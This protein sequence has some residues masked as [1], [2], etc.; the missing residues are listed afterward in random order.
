M[1]KNYYEQQLRRGQYHVSFHDGKS[2]H[3]DGSPFYDGKILH[4]R[5]ATDRFVRS[6][7]QAGY[8]ER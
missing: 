1:T 6:L 5:R 8:T 7:Q 4:N 2:T 3:N